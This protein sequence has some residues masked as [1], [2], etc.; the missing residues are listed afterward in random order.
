VR[1]TTDVGNSPGADEPIEAVQLSA[2]AEEAEAEALQAEARAAAARARARAIQLRL[3]TENAQA[4]ATPEAAAAIGQATSEDRSESESVSQEAESTTESASTELQPVA[5]E[6]PM[7][8]NRWP[9][10]LAV[11]G[12]TASIVLMCVTGTATGIMWWQHRQAA[13]DRQHSG[14]FAGAARQ[15][16][17]DLMSLDFAHAKDDVQRVINDA[18]GD[19]RKDL[20]SHRDDFIAAV[21]DSKVVTTGEVKAVAVQSMSA[22]DATVLVAASSKV[23]NAEGA[24]QEQRTWRVTVTLTRIGDQVKMSK[25]EFMP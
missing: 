4:T 6:K 15:G 11:V 18:S 8:R 12:A 22:D 5:G 1:S 13:Q 9:Y 7:R 24:S 19:F 16:V 17:V 25:V 3:K 2:D 20:E 23:A 14:E 21:Q 10:R